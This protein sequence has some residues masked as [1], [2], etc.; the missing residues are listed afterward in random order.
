MYK[1]EEANKEKGKLA[2]RTSGRMQGVSLMTT[3]TLVLHPPSV[4]RQQR[5]SLRPATVPC[6]SRLTL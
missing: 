5:T 1:G 3:A 6:P 4:E 2:T